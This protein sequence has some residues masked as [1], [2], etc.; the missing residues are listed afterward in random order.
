M[1]S[2]RILSWE[3]FIGAAAPVVEVFCFESLGS[4]MDKA[5]ELLAGAKRP[6]FV[7][8]KSQTAGRGRQG[9]QWSEAG[10]GLY[11]TYG[12]RS[13]LDLSR[14]S[15]FSLAVGAVAAPILGGLGADIGLKW[16]NDIVTKNRRKLGGILIE[17]FS[18]RE[19]TTILV[20]IG[21]NISRPSTEIRDAA[22]LSDFTDHPLTPPELAGLILP[23]LAEL[24]HNFEKSGF[25]GYKDAWLSLS[26]PFG[27]E[28][29]IEDGGGQT[30]GVYRGVSE[31]GALILDTAEGPR[32]FSGGHIISWG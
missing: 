8:A 29:R 13:D 2:E 18:N 26:L 6:V 7:M 15:G 16:P 30:A 27:A 24:K 4:T 23:V 31:A 19:W 20:G 21:I 25:G 14:F 5:R 3:A 10:V 9:R 17:A 12:F 22:A 11:A 28:V 32:E 1:E